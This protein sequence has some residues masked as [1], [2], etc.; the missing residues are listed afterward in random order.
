MDCR[1]RKI[2]EIQKW[3]SISTICKILALMFRE[4]IFIAFGLFTGGSQEFHGQ[5]KNTDRYKEHVPNFI[6][7]Y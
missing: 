3:V 4:P 2:K 5:R 6:P 7:K 1:F